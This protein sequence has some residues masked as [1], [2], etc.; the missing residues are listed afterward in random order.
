LPYVKPFN[1]HYQVGGLSYGRLGKAKVYDFKQKRHDKY[2]EQNRV[3]VIYI[4]PL[5]YEKGHRGGLL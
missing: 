1:L 3:E 5:V 4:R 2:Y